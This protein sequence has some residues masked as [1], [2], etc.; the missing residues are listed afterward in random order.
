MLNSI[1]GQMLR[2]IELGLKTF[3]R[4]LNELST[5]VHFIQ[6][7]KYKKNLGAGYRS[8]SLKNTKIFP[9]FRQV[10]SKVKPIDS[11]W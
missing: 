6:I 7:E 8:F 1:Y 10:A 9:I 11:P 4:E 5:D 2:P 3:D